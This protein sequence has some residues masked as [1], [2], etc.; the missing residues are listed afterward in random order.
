[1]ALKSVNLKSSGFYRCEVSAERPTF[2]S[3]EGGGRME[4]VCESHYV[5]L[6]FMWAFVQLSVIAVW[7][8][9][10]FRWHGQCDEKRH[11]NDFI[12]VN[13]T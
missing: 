6:C 13:V 3:A 11:R 4:V 12:F 1:V 8:C 7:S 9:V 5:S 2:T 10:V